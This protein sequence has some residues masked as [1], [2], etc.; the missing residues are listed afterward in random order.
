MFNPVDKMD[1][2]EVVIGKKTSQA[3]VATAASFAREIGKQPIISAN[4][5]GYVVNRLLFIQINE[6]ISMME[7]GI[8]SKE[9]IDQA[10]KL[11]LKHPMGPFELA[12]HIGLD[13]CH[14]ILSTIYLE[15]DDEKYRPARTLTGLV[16]LGK[17]GRKS[18]EGFYQYQV[19]KQII[20][21][22]SL[23]LERPC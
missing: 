22:T 14:A 18:G 19:A 17:C 9:D 12:D 21:T 7:E 3:T 15:L 2:V 23:P 11:G 6:A 5:P 4:S 8:A 10:M 20:M 1:L 16:S 13:I